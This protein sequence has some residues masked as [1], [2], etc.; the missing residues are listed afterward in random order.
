MKVINKYFKNSNTGEILKSQEFTETR[1]TGIPIYFY[2]INGQPV[3]VEIPL[4]GFVEI[5]EKHFLKAKNNSK[6][7]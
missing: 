2:D 5:N 7:K 6:N 3:E 1:I 4:K